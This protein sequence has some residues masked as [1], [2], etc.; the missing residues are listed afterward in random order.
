MPAPTWDQYMAPSGSSTSF[1]PQPHFAFNLY[2]GM[3]D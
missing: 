3:C 1:M 2:T